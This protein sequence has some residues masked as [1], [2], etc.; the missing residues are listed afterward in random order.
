M[1]KGLLEL[2]SKKLRRD[3]KL[4]NKRKIRFCG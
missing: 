3:L 1:K 4:D 2:W